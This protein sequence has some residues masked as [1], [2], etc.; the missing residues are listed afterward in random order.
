L[1]KPKKKPNIL[2]IVPTPVHVIVLLKVLPISIIIKRVKI[3][4]AIPK[5]TLFIKSDSMYSLT[6][7]LNFG[8]KIIVIIVEKTHFMNEIKLNEKPLKKH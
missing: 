4:I 3:K 6:I 5:P 1:K 2:S 7:G 8:T